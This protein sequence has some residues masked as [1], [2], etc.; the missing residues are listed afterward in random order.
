MMDLSLSSSVSLR[1]FERL[2][3]SV[4]EIMQQVTRF[5]ELCRVLTHYPI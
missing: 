2:F 5:F 4:S 1:Q 3:P